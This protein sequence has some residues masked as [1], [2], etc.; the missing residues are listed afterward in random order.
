MPIRF[1]VAEL[2]REK[3]VTGYAINK[4]LGASHPYVGY[5]LLKADA[6]DS[7][8]KESIEAIC[9][10]LDCEPGDFI[11]RVPDEQLASKTAG[12]NSR[13]K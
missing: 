12:K 5:R 11:V 13:K 8:S 9:V 6:Q 3:G 10:A 2:A 7:L 1:K 4:K